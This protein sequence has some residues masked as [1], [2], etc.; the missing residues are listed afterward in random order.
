MTTA[1]RVAFDLDKEPDAVRRSYGDGKFGLGCLMAR[2]LVEAGV[3]FIEVVLPGWDTHQK[4][5]ERV[6]LLAAELDRGMSALLGD[7]ASRGLLDST[8]VV[9]AGD[10]GRTPTINENGGRDHYPQVTPV[11]LAGGGVRGGQ[12]I[13]STD[14]GCTK[15]VQG[16]ATV[17]DLYASIAHALGLDPDET[18]MSPAG[19][20]I[21]TVENGSVIPHL[22]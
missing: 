20:P 17:G 14:A 15:V 7:L 8:L 5:L 11:V 2:R 6:K 18:R 4:N 19:R 9:W 21:P 22:F 3:P 1:H 10:F 16:S 13:G 12:V